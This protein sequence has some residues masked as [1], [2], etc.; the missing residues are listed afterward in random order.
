MPLVVSAWLSAMFFVVIDTPVAP[1]V[2]SAS[3]VASVKVP[4]S[5]VVVPWPVV[6]TKLAA[7]TPFASTLSALLIRIAS[8]GAVSPTSPV[9]VTLPVV[10]A[11]SVRSNAP[12]TV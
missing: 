5:S 9:K 2:F 10:P 8:S 3:V 6:C 11:V 7:R 1:V 12:S 4:P